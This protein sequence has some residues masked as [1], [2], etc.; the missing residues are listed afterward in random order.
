[1]HVQLTR[2][3]FRFLLVLN[4]VTAPQGTDLN[5]IYSSDKSRFEPRVVTP[6]GPVSFG[7]T[8]AARCSRVTSSSSGSRSLF[9]PWLVRVGVPLVFQSSGE[10]RGN[11]P[12]APQALCYQADNRIGS[13]QPLSL[14]LPICST[15]LF[16][17]SYFVDYLKF[18]S[19]FIPCLVSP[20]LQAFLGMPVD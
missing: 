17:Y 19:F 7:N 6:P 1:M 8:D 16:L 4:Q 2:T 20:Q 13:G 12:T 10:H 3:L 11:C 15:C 5:L 14:H 18:L 9:Q